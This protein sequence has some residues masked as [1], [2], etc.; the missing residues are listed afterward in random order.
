M[1]K[2]S[3][4]H[5]K[6]LHVYWLSQRCSLSLCSSSSGAASLR[7]SCSLKMRPKR[8]FEMSCINHTTMRRHILEERRADV[9]LSLQYMVLPHDTA[10]CYCHMILPHVTVTRYCHMVL[11]HFTA[12]CYFHMLLPHF[13]ATWYWHMLLS[14]GTANGTATC[15]CH[16]VLLHVTSTCYCHMV[17]P[18]VTVTRY[19]HMVLPHVTA[20]CY[21]HM[22]L[23]HGTTTY[24]LW[25]ESNIH[26]TSPI[27]SGFKLWNKFESATLWSFGGIE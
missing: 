7:D 5:N 14:H 10:T 25:N 19:C 8:R 1:C 21:F 20:T 16:I 24:A 27:A 11:T 23:P 12:T 2:Y 26:L 4:K 9:F 22:L 3:H 18:H 17:L 6:Y 13:T 15:Y